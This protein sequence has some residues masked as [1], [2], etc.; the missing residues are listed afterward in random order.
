[1]KNQDVKNLL[2]NLKKAPVLLGISAF[3]LLLNTS[4]GSK[5]EEKK[6]EEAAKDSAKVI[7]ERRDSMHNETGTTSETTVH[8]GNVEGYVAFK[9]DMIQKLEDEKKRIKEIR[10]EIK[11]ETKAD[12]KKDKKDLIDAEEKTDKLR[13][14]L[15][16]TIDTTGVAWSEFKKS[17]V[18]DLDEV[19][20]CVD[21]VSAHAN[22][23]IKENK[24]E[25]KK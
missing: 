16:T 25:E 15:S 2:N 10:S 18:T 13:E 24:K 3:T 6:E 21:N 4:C 1:M 5:H 23:N 14:R 17:F 9:A 20:K 19:K 8:H 22:A 12:R 11:D 7:E